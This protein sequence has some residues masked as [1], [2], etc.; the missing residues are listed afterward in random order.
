MN[1]VDLGRTVGH[2]HVQAVWPVTRTS[3]VTKHTKPQLI[4]GCADEQTSSNGL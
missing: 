2:T 3:Q 1:H 4:V